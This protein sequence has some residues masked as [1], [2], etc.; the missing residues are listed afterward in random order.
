MENSEEI[1]EVLDKIS[2]PC[3]IDDAKNIYRHKNQGSQ[4]FNMGNVSL[5]L[6]LIKEILWLT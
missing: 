5:K 1:K 6:F 4:A 2:E 3:P